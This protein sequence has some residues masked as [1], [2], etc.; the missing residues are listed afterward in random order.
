ME[1]NEFKPLTSR[2]AQK[3]LLIMVTNGIVNRPIDLHTFKKQGLR[4]FDIQPVE[5]RQ[6]LNLDNNNAVKW[7]PVPKRIFFFDPTPLYEKIN[8]AKVLNPY[9]RQCTV[10]INFLF[11]NK[12]KM[13]ACGCGKELSGRQKRWSSKECNDFAFAVFAIISGYAN[14]LRQ[15]RNIFIGGYKCEICGKPE[16]HEAIELDHIY[17]VKFGGGGGWLSNYQFKCKKCH[18]EKTNKDFGFKQTIQMPTLF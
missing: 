11:D 2:K 1:K 16:D 10:S 5:C 4:L 13:C 3:Q 15:Y 6:P 12:G 8:E 18:R 7:K 17:P 14:T 9:Q